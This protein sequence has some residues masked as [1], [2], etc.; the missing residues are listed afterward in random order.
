M[1]MDQYGLIASI[2]QAILVLRLGLVSL[3][4]LVVYRCAW[5]AVRFGCLG[6]G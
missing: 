1:L 2:Y 4:D 3:V 6:L 5:S